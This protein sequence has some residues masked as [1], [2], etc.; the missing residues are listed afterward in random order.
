M[1]IHHYLT[2][3]LGKLPKSPAGSQDA[4]CC[5]AQTTGQQADNRGILI[6]FSNFNGGKRK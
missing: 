3:I 2:Q 5:T 4:C 1:I 6:T